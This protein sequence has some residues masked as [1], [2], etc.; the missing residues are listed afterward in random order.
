MMIIVMTILLQ[1]IIIT[2]SYSA[3][4]LTKQ[5]IINEYIRARAVYPDELFVICI[6]LSVLIQTE[7]I[8]HIICN[9][10]FFYR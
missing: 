6:L 9:E 10:L 3:T 5:E 8:F 4:V 1:T 7:K 2:T